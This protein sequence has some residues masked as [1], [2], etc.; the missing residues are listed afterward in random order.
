MKDS[1]ELVLKKRKWVVT[2]FL[3]KNGLMTRKWK[4][5][6]NL[7]LVFC[8]DLVKSGSTNNS[9]R[10][11]V[12]SPLNIKDTF[13]HPY[14]LTFFSRSHFLRDTHP[15]LVILSTTPVCRVTI[16]HAELCRSCL[17]LNWHQFHLSSLL[18][19]ISFMSCRTPIKDE[20]EIQLW[21]DVSLFKILI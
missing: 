8:P 13:V 2:V 15:R 21:H 6:D 4:P 12:Y 14:I 18:M 7:S 16:N 9:R 20:E 19:I 10:V 3:H 5:F 17:I 11:L 1:R